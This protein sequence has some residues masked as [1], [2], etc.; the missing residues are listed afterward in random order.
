MTALLSDLG[1]TRSRS[2]ISS[3]FAF[4]NYFTGA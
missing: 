4:D 3:V 1:L 2:S